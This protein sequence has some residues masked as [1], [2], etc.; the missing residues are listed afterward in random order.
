M[1]SCNKMIKVE[2][3]WIDQYDQITGIDFRSQIYEFCLHIYLLQVFPSPTL[4]AYLHL[5]ANSQTCDRRLRSHLGRT[6]FPGETIPDSPLEERSSYVFLAA[7]PI[8]RQKGNN[9]SLTSG[10]LSWSTGSHDELWDCR[11]WRMEMEAVKRPCTLILISLF[12]ILLNTSNNLFVCLFVYSFVCLLVSWF[13]CRRGRWM[14][15]ACRCT[16][17]LSLREQ[18]VKLIEQS[19]LNASAYHKAQ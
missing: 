17:A 12:G 6:C 16:H 2:S 10:G 3:C 1:R 8:A 15:M 13:V 9:S 7:S 5:T 14:L 11:S 19:D 18:S 4:A